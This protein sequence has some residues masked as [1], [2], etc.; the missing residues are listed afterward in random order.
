MY[1]VIGDFHFISICINYYDKHPESIAQAIHVPYWTPPPF[2]FHFSEAGLH[3]SENI[4]HI[5]FIKKFGEKQPKAI[6]FFFVI[7]TKEKDKNNFSFIFIEFEKKSNLV[8][9]FISCTNS[10]ISLFIYYCKK[11]ICLKAN[12]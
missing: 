6:N 7:E 9:V 2:F 1:S 12:V 3:T 4:R 11:C 5:F 10:F 8:L